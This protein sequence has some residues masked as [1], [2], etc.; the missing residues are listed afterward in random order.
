M[1]GDNNPIN[2]LKERLVNKFITKQNCMATTAT[3]VMFPILLKAN[4]YSTKLESSHQKIMVY[5]LQFQ[6]MKY[7]IKKV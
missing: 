3:V 4:L 7:L 2:N 5:K 1:L 6:L